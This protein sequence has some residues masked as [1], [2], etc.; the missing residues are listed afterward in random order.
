MLHLCF[1][2][3]DSA[4]AARDSRAACDG[5]AGDA[6]EIGRELD[7]GESGVFEESMDRRLLAVADFERDETAGDESGEGL[8]DEATIDAEPVVG[9]EG[10]CGLVIANFDGEGIAIGG[11]DVWRVGDDNVEGLA[12]DW[13]E[14]I[15]LEEANDNS[16]ATR[17]LLGE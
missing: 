1:L 16:V 14:E 7:I 12:V 17:V 8:R 11:G 10:E 13:G 3:F 2:N 15:A 6:L 5:D 9:E 4:T